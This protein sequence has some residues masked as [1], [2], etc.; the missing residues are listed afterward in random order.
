MFATM[1]IKHGKDTDIFDC[2]RVLR[3]AYEHKTESMTNTRNVNG[4][5]TTIYEHLRMDQ[6]L[7]EYACDDPMYSAEVREKFVSIQ[8]LAG[9]DRKHYKTRR[10]YFR[11]V[12]D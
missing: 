10:K 1:R 3:T 2:F 12:S 7:C 6:N 5:H 11:I 4:Y 9:N 8:K